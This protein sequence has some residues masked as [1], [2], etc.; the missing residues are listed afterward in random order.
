MGELAVAVAA[1]FGIIA[2][3]IQIYGLVLIIRVLQRADDVLYRAG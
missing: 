3:A 1:L 2:V